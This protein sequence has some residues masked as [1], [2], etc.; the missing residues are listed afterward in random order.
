[1]LTKL[2]RMRFEGAAC[3]FCARTSDDFQSYS[4][5]EHNSAVFYPLWLACVSCWPLISTNSRDDLKE[6]ATTAA[7]RW[8]AEN[9]GETFNLEFVLAGQEDFWRRYDNSDD[10]VRK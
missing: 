5:P 4:S 3:S 7:K 1:M 9:P 10:E 6:R 2:D 8:S